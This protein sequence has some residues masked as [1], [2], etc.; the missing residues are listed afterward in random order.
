MPPGLRKVAKVKPPR[1]RKGL[2]DPTHKRAI[3]KLPCLLRGRTCAIGGWR[4]L[5]P[6]KWVEE[7]YKHICIGPVEPHHS[8]K[9]AQRG[10]DHT[11][12]PLCHGAHREADTLTNEQFK[13]RWGIAL[14]V[15]ASQL[16]PK[17][18]P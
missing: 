2:D 17:A 6:K 11:C 4:G 12:V 3:K 14:P 9:K 18:Q 16:A 10:H 8:T 7:E 1:E 5:Y 15:I 13:A